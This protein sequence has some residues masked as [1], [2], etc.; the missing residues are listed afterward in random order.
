M[1]SDLS[2]QLESLGGEWILNI[3]LFGSA[4]GA[5]VTMLLTVFFCQLVRG[6]RFAPPPMN[7][8]EMTE[9][10]EKAHPEYFQFTGKV[11]TTVGPAATTTGMTHPSSISTLPDDAN[12]ATGGENLKL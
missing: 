2:Q 11:T 1:S 12:F 5:F 6:P 8:F 7:Y 9:A 3:V 4:F 10:D